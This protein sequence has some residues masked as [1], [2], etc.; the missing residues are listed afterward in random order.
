MSFSR[1]SAAC[2][3]P[4]GSRRLSFE[5]DACIPEATPCKCCRKH[6]LIARATALSTWN[7]S[8]R[9]LLVRCCAVL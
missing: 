8:Q 4:P 3:G 6:V 7:S 9:P 1:D 2:T 5:Q